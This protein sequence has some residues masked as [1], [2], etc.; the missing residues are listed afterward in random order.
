MPTV[1]YEPSVGEAG[2]STTPQEEDATPAPPR[3]PK[4]KER[5][6]DQT[7]EDDFDVE[8]PQHRENCLKAISVADS[9]A[10]LAD[11]EEKI[12][13][14]NPKLAITTRKLKACQA[15]AAALRD[16]ANDRAEHGL[17]FHHYINRLAEQ[18]DDSE[19]LAA[20]HSEKEQLAQEEVVKWKRKWAEL[21]ATCEDTPD[22]LP[23]AQRQD[24]VA[25][26]VSSA[27]HL[28]GRQQ[29]V[30]I[31]DPAPFTGKDD[32]LIDDWVFDM[33]NK[34]TQNSSEFDGEPLKI[35]YTARLVAGRARDFIRTR[36]KPGSVDPIV[37]AEQIF[38]ILQ[39]AYGKSDEMVEEEA[40]EE[41]RRLRQKDT[42][43]SSFWADFTRLTT[44]LGKN[45]KELID[46]LK[47]KMNLEL[48]EAVNDR[49]FATARELA[50]W[51]IAKENRN[52]L[53]KNR[54]RR[55]NRDA[56][57]PRRRVGSRPQRVGR[58]RDVP[59]P[60]GARPTFSRPKEPLRREPEKKP[61]R[62]D[63]PRCYE[64]GKT[65][66]WKKNCPELNKVMPI[67]EGYTDDELDPDDEAPSRRSS[68]EEASDDD[69]GKA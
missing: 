52:I 24:S 16:M 54:E 49:T 27:G 2:P 60:S 14:E 34:L 28:L 36:L 3:D 11:F 62:Q 15:L 30:R 19:A 56:E 65:G 6:R 53:I 46:G 20:Y 40:K 35:A 47:E 29:L 61:E 58:P 7:E 31:K 42:P 67:D 57:I 59:S 23:G 22:T 44:I 69:S 55:E 1:H 17:R 66:H 10:W 32:Y 13:K 37:S 9:E 21:R 38:A 45:P 48:L 50:D 39:Q 63:E 4:G 41:Y 68:D 43:F 5:Q 18:L 26:S 51:C 33:R 64:C 25:P 8:N 12:A